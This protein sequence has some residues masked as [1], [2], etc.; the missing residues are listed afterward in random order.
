MVEPREKG[1]FR[2]PGI[3]EHGDRT[4]EEQS[5]GLQPGLD[6]A[7]GKTALDLGCAEGAISKLFAQAGAR[8]VLG[9]EMLGRHLDIARRWC[10]DVPQVRF[11][12][13]NL[14]HYIDTHE[15]HLQYDIVLI[16]AI[17]HKLEFPEVPLRF[18]ARTCSDLLIYR[19]P[20]NAK[21]GWVRS[22][23]TAN[24]AH[25]P[26]VLAEE[27]FKHEQTLPGPRDEVVEYWRRIK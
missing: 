1:W 12:K 8:E 10:R 6:E 27:G 19:P 24:K 9:I 25:V 21:D 5:A 20:A 11:I 14:R 18:A 7:H 3:R 15:E 16:L 26:T 22:K 17:I 2:I 23:F 4:I 13:D